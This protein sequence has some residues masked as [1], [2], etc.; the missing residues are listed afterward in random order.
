[1]NLEFLKQLVDIDSRSQDI[2]GVNEVQKILSEALTLLNFNVKLLENNQDNS[3]KLLW[4]QKIGQSSKAITLVCHADTVFGP[5]ENFKFK[6][7]FQNGR[8]VGP[9]IGDNKGGI[10]L[11][12]GAL[13]DFLDKYK[14]HFYTINVVCSPSEE[15]G[16]IGFHDL[17][18]S[19]GDNSDF[20]FGFEPALS[21]GDIISERSGNRWYKIKIKG[22]SA[23][24][25]RWNEP[26]INAAHICADIISEMSQLTS[27]ELKRRVNVA[28]IHGG[29]EKYNVV[30]G[31]IEF[32]LDTRFKDFES[33]DLIHKT[34]LESFEKYKIIDLENKI[35]SNV[36]SVEFCKGIIQS[37]KMF[38]GKRMYHA[39]SGGAADINYFQR[40][41][42]IGIDGLGPIAY[43]MHSEEEYIEIESFYT[44]RHVFSE[45]LVKLNSTF[46]EEYHERSCEQ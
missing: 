31:D 15:I 26:S 46:K 17:F 3:G 37:I 41:G 24:A 13:K 22:Q 8:V 33:R 40:P 32:K 12:V 36:E 9:G 11:L 1:V 38:E 16:S 18:S 4:A 44:R 39:F 23:H 5:T 2:N 35:S 45:L 42:I 28:S 29:V 21:S 20:V 7:D 27:Y 30:C 25:G 43:R 34:L 6:I 10:A 19:I 14:S